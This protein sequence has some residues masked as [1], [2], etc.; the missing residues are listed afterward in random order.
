MAAFVIINK[1]LSMVSWLK[2]VL[3]SEQVL[4]DGVERWAEYRQK[5]EYREVKEYVEK[6][7]AIF[8]VYAGRL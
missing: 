7:E 6:E 5:E 2:H 8:K 1:I 3:N 4:I